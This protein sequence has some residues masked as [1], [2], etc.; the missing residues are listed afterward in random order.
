MS[1]DEAIRFFQDNCYY[2]Y[3]PARSE[4][5]RG[6]YDP[7]YLNYTLGKLMIL[8]LREDYKKQEGSGYS[9]Q[10]FH[11]ALLSNGMP[12]ILVLRMILLKDPSI[13]REVI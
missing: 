5:I 9:L 2:E 13:H 3:Q 7:G 4:A 11:D 6:T 12:P 8:K 10:K 1:V